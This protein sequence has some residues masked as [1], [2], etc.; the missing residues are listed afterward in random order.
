MAALTEVIVDVR[1]VADDHVI[2]IQLIENLQREGLHE[3]AEAEG[4]E[5]LQKRGHSVD[6]IADKVGKSRGYVYSRMK[7]LALSRA[8]RKAFYEGK[9]T[10]STAL[11]LARIPVEA[12][13]AEALKEIITIRWGRLRHVI[14]AGRRAH[15]QEIHDQSVGCRLSDRGCDPGGGRR[16][17]RR[18]SEAHRKSSRTLR[19]CKKWERMHGSGVLQGEARSPCG[20]RDRPGRGCR[21]KVISGKEAKIIAPYGADSSNL[22]GYTAL[23]AK[24]YEDPKNRTVRQLLGKDY[25]P[26]LLHDPETGKLVKVAAEAD[27]KKALRDAGVKASSSGSIEQTAREKKAKAEREFRQALFT[28]VRENYPASLARP[29]WNDLV[30][31]MLHEMQ[32]DTVK[33]VFKLWG[34][35]PIKD[36]YSAGYRK[37]AAALVSKLSAADMTKLL[38]DCIFVSD[39]QVSTWS[40]AKPQKLF[41]R[42]QNDSRSTPNRCDARSTPRR[43]PRPRRKRR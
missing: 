26:T 13:Q 28:K 37:A 12:V 34:W 18:V 16:R 11:L 15:P 8:A 1:Q 32:Q 42:R 35:E 6:E 20:T 2:D 4:Y 23:D 38:F 22:R 24:P 39:L 33:Q 31:A 43:F 25:Q 9:L 36:G 29:D 5:E 17:L 7:L 10:A 14:P 40:D 3:L 41:G 21:Q 27:V 19:R 30:L